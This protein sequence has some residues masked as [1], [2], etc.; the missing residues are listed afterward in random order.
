MYNYISN[1][2]FDEEYKVN[3]AC[4]IIRHGNFIGVIGYED[5][6]PANNEIENIAN[7]G[8]YQG[9]YW[10]YNPFPDIINEMIDPTML[11]LNSITDKDPYFKLSVGDIIQLGRLRLLI[12]E[13]SDN[14]NGPIT[15]KITSTENEPE[16]KDSNL[17]IGHSINKYEVESNIESSKGI[18]ERKTEERTDE[19]FED[20]TEEKKCRICLCNDDEVDNP[21]IES[22]CNCIG[23]VRYIHM[24]CLNQWLKNKVTQYKNQYMTLYEWKDFKCDI[25]KI[26]YPSIIL[27]TFRY[28]NI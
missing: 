5:P 20:K 15:Q 17:I 13:I 12:K 14:S 23:S 21:I 28:Y 11:I 3:E 22:P 4:R 24:D 2:T 1:E 6:I 19:R 8:I 7:V 9:K 27:L 25:C 10:V 16:C 26:P 18:T